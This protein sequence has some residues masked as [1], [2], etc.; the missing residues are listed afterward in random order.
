MYDKI[1]AYLSYKI[2]G[3]EENRTE[4][5][6]L[7]N[8]QDAVEFGQQIRAKLPRLELFVPHEWEFMHGVAL[9]QGIMTVEELLKFDCSVIRL[10]DVVILGCPISESKGCTVE[11]QEALK[12]NI[13]V[14]RVPLTNKLYRMRDLRRRLEIEGFEIKE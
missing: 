4:W 14:I 10:C 7:Q 6:I 13:P 2:R 3:Q 8:I 11:Y 12:H 9:K 5:T 1:K